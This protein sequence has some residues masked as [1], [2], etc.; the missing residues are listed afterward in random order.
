MGVFAYKG[1]NGRGDLVEGTLDGDD[2]GVIADQ[3][4][5]TGITPTEII[6][7]RGV[8][9]GTSGKPKSQRR[10]DC[11]LSDCAATCPEQWDLADG[12]RYFLAG[13]AA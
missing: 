12:L 5:N 13:R 11:A 8:L 7:F 4:M 6:Q 9:G 10:G 2:S 3:L 1:R